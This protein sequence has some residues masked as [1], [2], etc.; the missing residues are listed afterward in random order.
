[1]MQV[2]EFMRKRRRKI[3]WDRR[4][5]DGMRGAGAAGVPWLH[6]KIHQTGAGAVGC[7]ADLTHISQRVRTGYPMEQRCNR[8]MI[9]IK[10]SLLLASLFAAPA[11]ALGATTVSLGGNLTTSGALTFN[12]AG[13][14]TLP[15]PGTLLNSAA[16]PSASTSQIY[17][18]TGTAGAATPLSSLPA[19]IQS[20]IT[21][22]GTLTAGAW[23]GTAVAVQ[24]GGT[25]ASTASGALA[26]LGGLAAATAASTY[27]PLVSPAFTGTPTINGHAL[28]LG[29]AFTTSGA[30]PLTL[31]LSGTTN[32][33]LQSGTYT[34]AKAGANTDI[35]SLNG[36]GLEIGNTSAITSLNINRGTIMEPTS[37]EYGLQLYASFGG[38]GGTG[39]FESPVS[40][41]IPND[42]LSYTGSNYVEGLNI[43]H[44]FGNSAY[45]AATCE[46]TPSLCGTG[47]RAAASFNLSMT[48]PTSNPSNT[49][50]V[51]TVESVSGGYNDGGTAGYAYARGQFTADNQ[52]CALYS[53]ATYYAEMSCDEADI[54]VNTG[55]SIR[56]KFGFIV[57]EGG[58]DTQ[59]GSSDD[60]ALDFNSE[61]GNVGWKYLIGDSRSGGYPATNASST[62]F[63]CSAA[64]STPCPAE[65][66]INLL[67]NFTWAAGSY[68][69]LSPGFLVDYQGNVSAH[70]VQTPTLEGSGATLS[71]VSPT[72]SGLMALAAYTVSGLPACNA[73]ATGDL[74][75]VSDALAPTF[76][77]TLS[78]G[79]ST[80]T[81]AFCNGSNWTA[82]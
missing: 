32:P 54:S 78:G 65:Y 62:I 2:V 22:V 29:G 59:Q 71:I 41:T 82:H 77:A 48:G 63:G 53:G 16:L 1:M 40:I 45:S 34:L 17:G 66:G 81:L 47:A 50:Y 43:Q 51:G 39:I 56:Q 4:C 27:A 36:S 26:N 69:F 6:G 35:T 76:N 57:Q 3:N 10:K 31:T 52:I 80:K 18:G 33:T 13:T 61:S 15:A 67:T 58:G 14:F 79:S 68:P 60:Q 49:N 19:A 42:H 74:A 38:T 37:L 75:Y 44:N 70:T 5:E 12:G 9:M 8:G 73:A 25:G 7:S 11:V 64:S 24:Y 23:D 72:I 55:A 46:A 21:Q 20:A 30:F 28:I